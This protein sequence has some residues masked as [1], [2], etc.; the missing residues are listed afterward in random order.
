MIFLYYVPGASE[1]TV[2]ESPAFSE[3][4]LQIVFRDCLEALAFAPS[5]GPDGEPGLLLYA[6]PTSREKPF[7]L[8]YRPSDQ[9]WIDCGTH[10]IGIQN[11]SP[12]QPEGLR[13]K[14]VLDSYSYAMADGREWLCPKIRRGGMPLVPAYWKINQGNF[15][16]EV[17]EEFADIWEQSADWAGTVRAI[18]YMEAF[19]ICALCLG[20][21][22]RLGV[23]EI[24]ALNMLDMATSRDVILAALDEQFFL[25]MVNQKKTLDSDTSGDSEN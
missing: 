15:R 13:R 21:N 7:G 18:S 2:K 24:S 6:I 3:G 1:A 17:K 10:W 4:G 16:L 12:P 19:Q 14:K 25:D 20:L 11:D 22:Y 9:T 23:N 8:R 5:K